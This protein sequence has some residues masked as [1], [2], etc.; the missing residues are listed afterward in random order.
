MLKKFLLYLFVMVRKKFTDA[1]LWKYLERSKYHRTDYFYT[2]LSW[3]GL[4]IPTFAG[5][6]SCFSR[7]IESLHVNPP[8]I[9]NSTVAGFYGSSSLVLGIM[10]CVF[11]GIGVGEGVI[12]YFQQRT[13]EANEIRRIEIRNREI[14]D[15]FDKCVS[16]QTE[17][18]RSQS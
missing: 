17:D 6:Y 2:A 13:L 18:R 3:F 10:G 1:E 12:P 16:I 7:V 11:L 15:L 5:A 8:N 4:S 9:A 14:D